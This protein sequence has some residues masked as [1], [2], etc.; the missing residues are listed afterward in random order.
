MGQQEG[1]E[2][3][4]EEGTKIQATVPDESQVDVYI[5]GFWK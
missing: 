2:Q 3:E 1:E 4:G 5:H